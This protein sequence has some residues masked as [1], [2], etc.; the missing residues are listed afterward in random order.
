MGAGVALVAVSV[1]ET[2][3]VI[4]RLA[5]FRCGDRLFG[6]RFAGG[7]QPLLPFGEGGGLVIGI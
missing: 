1:Y 7:G 2:E 5:V 4:V 6:D 3:F